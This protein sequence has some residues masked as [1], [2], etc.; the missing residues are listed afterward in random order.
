MNIKIITPI[1]LFVLGMLFA[2]LTLHAQQDSARYAYSTIINQTYKIARNEDSLQLDLFIPQGAKQKDV[3][4]I[5][6]VH[7]GGWAFGNKDLDGIPYTRMLKQKL[8]Q[9]EIAVASISYSLVSK[10][11][12]FPAPIADCKDAVRWLRA[13][14][15]QYNLDT[16]TIGV[17]GGS[18]GAHLAL[19]MAYTS[20]A[21]FPG[22]PQLKPYSARVSYVVD[23]FGPT[24]LNELFKVDLNGFS[25]FMFKVFIR[26]LY[27]IRNKLTLAM[28]GYDFKT[29][30]DKVIETNDRYSPLRFI[31]EHAVPTLILHG[32]KDKIVSLNQSE[33]LKD[34]LDR[35]DIPNQLIR[36]D[37]GDHGFNK[38]GMKKTEELV[39]ITVDFI[40]RHT[41][42]N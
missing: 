19:L 23:N 12:H 24:D 18:A 32:T 27:D 9:Q 5:V 14:A 42:K 28:T 11:V 17:W 31:N 25:T 35:Y 33:V 15:K 26:R 16:T 2:C 3:P 39:N 22:D 37:K 21:E 8:L 30:R 41:G 10:D 40:Q 4:V 13:N 34:T 38:I 36:V 1:K 29:D 6:V 20:E 7:G